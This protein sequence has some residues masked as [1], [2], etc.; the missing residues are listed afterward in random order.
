MDIDSFIIRFWEI[1]G[2][3]VALL[4]VGIFFSL[5]LS[6]FNMFAQVGPCKTKGYYLPLTYI[7]CTINEERTP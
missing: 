1:V 7:I 4:F 6:F 5:F 3:L 2:V